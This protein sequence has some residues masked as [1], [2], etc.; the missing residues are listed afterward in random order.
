[1]PRPTQ[2]LRT[3]SA[4]LALLAAAS[5]ALLAG[6]APDAG[7]AHRHGGADGRAGLAHG[8][9]RSPPR[10]PSRRAVRDRLRRAADGRP[11]STPSTRTSAPTPATKPPPTNVVA[12]VEEEPARRA[13]GSTRR[14]ARSSRWASR[15]PTERARGAHERGGDGS[16]PVPT[17]GTPPEVEGYFAQAGGT[18]EAQVFPGPYWIV[19]DSV[20]LFEPGDAQQLV[21]AVLRQPPA[22]R[23]IGPR[24]PAPRATGS[25]GH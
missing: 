6:C 7:R 24:G 2:P 4:G 16:K 18:G 5:V 12:V 20:A 3:R 11:G 21:A 25:S 13:A 15:R 19:V 1:M 22:G 9:R 23:L 8:A 17:Y 14:A 10:R